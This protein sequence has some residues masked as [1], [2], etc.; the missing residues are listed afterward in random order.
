MDDDTFDAQLALG[1]AASA[2]GDVPA[3]L[4]CFARASALDPL[5]PLPAF[6][7]GAEHA[8]QGRVDEA[9]AA[10]AAGLLLAPGFRLLRYQ[11]GLLQFTSGRAA[12]ALVTWEPLLGPASDALAAFVRGFAALAGDDVPGALQHWAH[13]LAASGPGGPVAA[14]IR[15]L[16]DALRQHRTDGAAEPPAPWTAAPA[17]VVA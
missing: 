17:E 16:A 9:E 5:S 8:A 4:A 12:A 14:D 13:G 3:A 7:A 1:L 15:L 2:G 6:L 10:Y 11:L